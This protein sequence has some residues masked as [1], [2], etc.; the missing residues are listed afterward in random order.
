MEDQIQI[1]IQNQ[2][3]SNQILLNAEKEIPNEEVLKCL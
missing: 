2:I 1:Q 3:K